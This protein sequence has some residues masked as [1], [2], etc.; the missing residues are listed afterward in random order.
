MFAL[1]NCRS[2][3]QNDCPPP[4]QSMG[5]RKA[6]PEQT[7]MTRNQQT[8]L[9]SRLSEVSSKPG[10]FWWSST[11]GPAPVFNRGK[12]QELI[13]SFVF[14]LRSKKQICS[15]EF[16]TCIQPSHYMP[17]G[18]INLPAPSF[19]LQFLL[20]LSCYMVC[21]IMPQEL[22]S[23]LLSCPNPFLALLDTRQQIQGAVWVLAAS[24]L[25]W[26]SRCA[27]SMLVGCP[28]LS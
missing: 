16:T 20:C 3:I 19:T 4:A 14:L 11:L 15:S 12:W 21:L 18:W 24:S 7:S 27:G 26:P 25:I 28:P 9:M 23:R 5:A 13:F 2:V 17:F 10:C 8:S 1:A 6:K 22:C